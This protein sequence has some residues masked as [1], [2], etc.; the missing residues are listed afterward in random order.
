VLRRREKSL[1]GIPEQAAQKNE[2]RQSANALPR[3]HDVKT[4]SF[5]LRIEVADTASNA[6]KFGSFRDFLF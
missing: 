1:T 2:H 4:L 6:S 5:V 3:F